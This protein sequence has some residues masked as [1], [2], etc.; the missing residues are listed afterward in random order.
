MKAL[1]VIIS[2]A[3]VLCIAKFTTPVEVP[4]ESLEKLLSLVDNMVED[5]NTLKAE[6]AIHL[7]VHDLTTPIQHVTTEYQNV[8]PEIEKR[9]TPSKHVDYFKNHIGEGNALR[10]R[11]LNNFLNSKLT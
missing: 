4:R 9:T 11:L 8:T 2:M 10:V 1:A 7:V 5:L 3:S 6:I